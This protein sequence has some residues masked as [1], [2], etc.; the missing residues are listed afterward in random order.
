MMVLKSELKIHPSMT[1]P[2]SLDNRLTITFG[3]PIKY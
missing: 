3:L 1:I 2:N